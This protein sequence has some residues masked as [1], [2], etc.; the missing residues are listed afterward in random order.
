MAFEFWLHEMRQPP[1]D[2]DGD[3]SSRLHDSYRA[4]ELCGLRGRSRK[5]GRGIGNPVEMQ[6]D[7][8]GPTSATSHRSSTSTSHTN[9]PWTQ[10]SAAEGRAVGSPS[11]AQ[12]CGSWGEGRLVP[13]GG[14]KSTAGERAPEGSRNFAGGKTSHVARTRRAAS[15]A[16]ASTNTWACV[17][18]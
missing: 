6:N 3:K 16:L 15:D 8:R 7:F 13:A 17:S 10:P 12:P 9:P 2:G 5:N 4:A 1:P 14:C 11:R 18:G